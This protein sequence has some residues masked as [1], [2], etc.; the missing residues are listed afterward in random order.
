MSAI[1]LWFKVDEVNIA[2]L[3]FKEFIKWLSFSCSLFTQDFS[4]WHW[5]AGQGFESHILQ[6]NCINM[7]EIDFENFEFLSIFLN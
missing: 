4:D 7:F 5:F 6:K 3:S 2:Y 1:L